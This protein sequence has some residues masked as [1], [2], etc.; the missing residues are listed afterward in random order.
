[1]GEPAQ[2]VTIP[3]VDILVSKSSD[4]TITR[5][6][7]LSRLLPALIEHHSPIKGTLSYRVLP[8]H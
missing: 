1:V 3:A 8:F 4:G 5:Q 7:R 2:E 6:A